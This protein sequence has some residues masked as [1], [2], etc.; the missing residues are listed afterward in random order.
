[1]FRNKT[2][3]LLFLIL[4]NLHSAVNAQD[5]SLLLSIQDAVSNSK[6]QPKFLSQ[7]KWVP[8]GTRFS[9]VEKKAADWKLYL[10]NTTNATIDSTLTLSRFNQALS[11][12]AGKNFKPLAAFPLIQWKDASTIWFFV[13][14]RW[15][16]YSFLTFRAKMILSLSENTQDYEFHPASGQVAY[17]F[18][19]NIYVASAAGYKQVT[20]DGGKGIVYG[21]AVHRNEFG[22]TKG[23]FWSNSGNRLA[24]YRMDETMVSDYPIFDLS[25]KPGG[26]FTIKYPVAGSASH[27]VTVGCWNTSSQQ[28]VYMQTGEPKEQYL[29]NITWSPDDEKIYIAIVA[30]EQ[31]YMSLNRYFVSDG[32]LDI[33]LFEE[34][35]AKYVEPEHGPVFLKN[36]EDKF[37][38]FSE[39]DGYNHLYLYN[40]NGRQ[41]AQVTS[42]KWVVTDFVGFREKDEKIFFVST[43]ESPLERNLYEVNLKGNNLK[44]V[45]RSDG[46]HTFFGNDS[47]SMFLD[48]YSNLKTPRRTILI[49]DQG[50]EVAEIYQSHNPLQFYKLG[51]TSVFPIISNKNILYARMI[52]PI[53]F[54]PERQYPVIVYLYGGPHLQLVTNSWLGGSN[55][56]MQFLAQQGFVVFTL[57]NRGSLNRGFEFESATFRQLGTVEMEDQLAGVEY[58]KK[59]SF[60]DESRIGVHGWSFG[61][62][63]TTTLM[64]RAPGVFKVGVAGGP[65]IDWSLYEIMYT[66]RYMD[67]PIENKEGYEKSNLINHIDK[68]QG[69]LLM[70]HGTDDDVV[71][72]QHSLLYSKAAVDKGVTGLDYFVYPGHKHNVY[73]KDRE[74]LMQKITEYLFENL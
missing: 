1:M 15:M 65:V 12:V 45:N 51:E 59:L 64:T 21:K 53:D 20:F 72:W 71:L 27:H 4:I 24:F 5:T 8:G 29:T 9:W 74:H 40:T 73:G 57:D 61:G 32:I 46:M 49:N 25:K 36:N 67:K 37:L 23:L 69:K 42:G 54:E 31:N 50:D 63:L 39:K 7:L 22:I 55:L 47:L 56:W 48:I 2:K 11:E 18:N 35:N 30:R 26:F 66:E 3:L 58:L 62:F 33:V 10:F 6:L 19:D 41:I 28:T 17:T 34:R 14:Y 70:I 60:V 44:K 52:K 43:K 13:Q 16:E 68:L 38:W